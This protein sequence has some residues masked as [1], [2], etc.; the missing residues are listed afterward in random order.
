MSD[1]LRLAVCIP[2][3]SHWLAQFGTSLVSMVAN[4]TMKKAPGYRSQELRVINI[5][6]SILSKNRLDSVKAARAMHA[7]YLLFL[8]TDHTF[9]ADLPQRLLAHGKLVVAANCVTKSLPAHPTA[10]NRSEVPNGVP[11]YSDP[12]SSGLEQVWRIGTGVMLINMKV[13]DKIGNGVWDMKYIPEKDTYQGEDWSFCEACEEHGIPLYIDHDVSREVGHLGL[14][15]Y[16]HDLVG[17]IIDG[18]QS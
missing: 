17:E 18:V 12:D 2:S 4:F 10:R 13:F 15:N 9:P 11:V 8:D 6:S 16:T 1:H 7:H 3:G 14:M 5:R